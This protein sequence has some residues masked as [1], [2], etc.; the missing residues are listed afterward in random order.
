MPVV[1]EDSDPL[2]EGSAPDDSDALDAAASIVQH[3]HRQVPPTDAPM[4]AGWWSVVLA[5]LS[6]LLLVAS[7]VWARHTNGYGPLLPI[8]GGLALGAVAGV[9]GVVG[10][11]SQLFRHRVARLE[12]AL[13]LVG[14]AVGFA[15]VFMGTVW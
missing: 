3:G 11:L 5:A 14:I 6:V 2:R 1:G 12:L 10:L 8:L 15:C 4:T 13:L 9:I 7:Q